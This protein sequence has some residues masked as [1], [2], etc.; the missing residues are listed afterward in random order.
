[1]SVDELQAYGLA[2]MDEAEVR[3]FLDEHSVGVLGLPAAE[4]PYLL[5]MSYANDGADSLYF[6][7][8]VGQS[9]QKAELTDEAELARFL[10]YDVDSMFEWR[11]VS[12]T[13]TMTA[14]PETRWGELRELLQT[15]W[16]PDV[17]RNAGISGRPRIYRLDVTECVGVKDTG[18][19]E[20]AE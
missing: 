8:V 1:M 3:S 2:V 13:G 17:L 16:R 7:Y 10:V 5:P 14:V 12:L 15:A 20:P 18:L 6:T 11:S 9:S 19:A 4:T